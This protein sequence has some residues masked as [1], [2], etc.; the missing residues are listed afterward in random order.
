MLVRRGA[1]LV[2][3]ACALAGGGCLEKT[4]A[5]PSGYGGEQP[6]TDAGVAEV[7]LGDALA[8][9]AVA[10]WAGTWTFTSG[11]EGLLCDG[12]LSA[13]AVSGGLAITASPS[14]RALDV[15]EDGCS[16]VFTLEGHTATSEANQSCAAWAIATIPIWTLTMQPDGTLLEKLG[17]Q[18]WVDGEP[19]EISGG[20]TLVRQ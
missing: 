14:G 20:S 13:S 7:A 17:G 5:T 4:P 16:F 11:S 9:G 8:D 12:S 10:A 1:T 19:C 2:L 6:T 3:A 15:Q 18:V